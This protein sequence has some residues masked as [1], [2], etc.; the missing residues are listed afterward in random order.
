[1]I[2]TDE[3]TS[4]FEKGFVGSTEFLPANAEPARAIGPGEEPF[5]YPVPRLFGGFQTVSQS[6]FEWMLFEG[7]QVPLMVVR[8]QGS[9]EFVAARV[10][11]S[12]PIFV[13]IAVLLT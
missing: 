2:K 3:S 6:R 8:V 4:Q 12:I 10:E 11:L 1:M 13:Q 7:L 5:H 9:M